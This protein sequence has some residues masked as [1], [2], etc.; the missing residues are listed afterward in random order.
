MPWRRVRRTKGVGNARSQPRPV[1]HDAEKGK[2]G[3]EKYEQCGT[4]AGP[5]TALRPDEYDQRNRNGIA[6]EVLA[7][8]GPDFLRQSVQRRQLKGRHGLPQIERQTEGRHRDLFRGMQ[9]LRRCQCNERENRCRRR[10]QREGN[11]LS[12]DLSSTI[13]PPASS[14]SNPTQR[15]CVDDQHDHWKR[16]CGALG[17]QRTCEQGQ[18]SPIPAPARHVRLHGAQI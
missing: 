3:R 11:Q 10:E 6:N 12:P 16:H 15:V 5:A 13:A 7:L 14:A 4:H 9:L 17:E 1:L 18:R 8:Q 2:N